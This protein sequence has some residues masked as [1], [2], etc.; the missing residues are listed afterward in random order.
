ML[1][2]TGFRDTTRLAG[3]DPAMAFDIAVTNREPTIHWLNRYIGALVDLRGLLEDPD[4][5]E[6]LFRQIAEAS[7]EYGAFIGGK[8]GRQE[9]RGAVDLQAVSFEQFLA[10][11][12]AHDKLQEI[13]RAHQGHVDVSQVPGRGLRVALSFPAAPCE[14]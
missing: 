7:F 12:W 14:D 5:D 6:A 11:G 4:A 1:C 2:A 3:T 8:V 9:A 10:G 13:M